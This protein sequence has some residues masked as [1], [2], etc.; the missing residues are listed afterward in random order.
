LFSNKFKIKKAKK[1][2]PEEK[3]LKNATIQLIEFES[4]INFPFAINTMLP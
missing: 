3:K 4:Y 2:N 1:N